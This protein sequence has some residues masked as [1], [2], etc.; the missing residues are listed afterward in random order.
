[1]LSQFGSSL[2]VANYAPRVVHYAPRVIS[3]APREHLNTGVTHDDR[4]MTIHMMIVYY[5][6][7]TTY[8]VLYVCC[9]GH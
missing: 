8:N 1:M 2:T 5:I 4:H 7:C 9:T 3:Y 6:Q